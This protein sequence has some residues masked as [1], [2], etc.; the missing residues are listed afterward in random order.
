MQLH[1][2]ESLQSNPHISW[3]LSILT[4]GHTALR[5]RFECLAVAMGSSFASWH[6][7][8]NLCAWQ[9][10]QRQIEGDAQAHERSNKLLHQKVEAVPARLHIYELH[11]IFG[12]SAAP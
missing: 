12:T 2:A 11:D 5:T 6:G 4:F 7:L 8:G 10:R 3:H 9:Q 1:N